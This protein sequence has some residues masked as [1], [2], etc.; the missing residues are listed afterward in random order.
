MYSHACFHSSV[1]LLLRAAQHLAL[2]VC[3]DLALENLSYAKTCILALKVCRDHDIVAIQLD[4]VITPIY[5][6]LKGVAD[7][8]TG[9][10]PS[11]TNNTD[12]STLLAIH[13]IV[14]RL[15]SAMAVSFKELWV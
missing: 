14:C 15:V 7:D 6:H 11:Q 3:H 9:S 13:S 4:H 2:G 10:V 1:V 8:P 12:G 5:E